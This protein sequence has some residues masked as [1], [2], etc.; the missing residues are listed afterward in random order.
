MPAAELGHFAAAAVHTSLQQHNNIW[1]IASGLLQLELYHQAQHPL[2]RKSF[3]CQ[4]TCITAE[5]AEQSAPWALRQKT[6]TNATKAVLLHIL[7]PGPIC[8]AGQQLHT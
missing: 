5:R 1:S 8:P 6:S 2:K 4:C 7:G 3:C